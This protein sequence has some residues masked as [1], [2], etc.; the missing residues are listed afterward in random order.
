MSVDAMKDMTLDTTPV[1]Q[2]PEVEP[3]TLRLATPDDAV[4]LALVSAATFLEAYTWMLPGA[5]IIAHC[6]KGLTPESY[7]KYLALPTTRIVLATVGLGAPVGYVMLSK[8]DLPDIETGPEDTELKRIYLFSRFRSS[9]T[10]VVG[11]PGVRT[12]QALMDAAVEQAR[13]MGCKRVLL[14]TNDG[15]ERAIAFY[16]RNGFKVAG[17]RTFVVGSKTCSDL[18]FAK[19]V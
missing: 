1:P 18:I 19:E 17:T 7:A 5:D 9:K 4:A 13:A 8:P 15:N 3:I 14:G 2:E 12:G 16:T 11:H 10:P 6:T